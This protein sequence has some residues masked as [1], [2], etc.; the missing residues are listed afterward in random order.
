MHNDTISPPEEV[1]NFISGS[2]KTSAADKLDVLS[3]LDGQVIATVP[4]SGYDDLDEA[5][6]A[7]KKAFPLWSARTLK[8]RTQ[9]IFTYRNL[10]VRER[11]SLSALIQ[12]EN[13]KTLDEARA[14]VDKSIELCE[15]ACSMPQ[16]VSYEV[17]EVS[18]GVEC[19][20]ERKPL[21]VVA[22]ITPFNFPAMV[23]NW[24]I[25]NALVLG[26]CMV[27]KPSEVVPLS[28]LRLAEL[29]QEAGLPAGVFSVVNGGQEV[30]EAR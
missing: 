23:P 15:F 9:Y 25:P 17:Q 4:L 21:G 11:E 5:V 26:N 14:E 27:L 16:I 28:A 22:S 18:K 13:G 24:T 30:V 6:Q 19:R 20:I 3:P 12:L 8:E 1:Q 7:A 10:L 2:F 29:L